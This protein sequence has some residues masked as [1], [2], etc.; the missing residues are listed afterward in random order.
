M[1]CC[2]RSDCQCGVSA[3]CVCLWYV[4]LPFSHDIIAEHMYVCGHVFVR[5]K[6]WSMSETV[7]ICMCVSVW[8]SHQFLM[9]RIKKAMPAFAWVCLC[10]EEGAALLA[11]HYNPIDSSL[12]PPAKG[13]AC[14]YWG[15]RDITHVMHLRSEG[16]NF[17]LAEMHTY[18]TTNTKNTF[19]RIVH[20][21]LLAHARKHD[22]HAM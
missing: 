12:K 8:I 16:L 10:G 13:T 22:A 19:H 6:Y 11:S 7:C 1:C 5:G 20:A 14:C 21:H 17:A 4:I 3:V 9:V 2:A 15:R 18:A